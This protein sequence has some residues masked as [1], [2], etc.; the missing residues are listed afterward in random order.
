MVASLLCD[1]FI[2]CLVP[3]S[4]SN[5]NAPDCLQTS[6]EI[7]REEVEVPEFDKITVFE[8]IALVLKQGD[9]QKVE[10]ATG[11][12]LWEEL[13]VAVEGDRLILRNENGCNFFREYGLTTVYVTSPNISEIRSSTGLA[14]TSDGV[15]SYPSLT[16]LSESFLVPEAETTDG[17][18]YLDLNTGDLSIVVNGIAYFKLRGNTQNLNVNI[19]AGDSRVE[20]Q[21]L[22]SQNVSINHRGS[23]DILVNPQESISGVIRG[24]GDVISYNR[25]NT[26][27]VSVIFNGKLVFRD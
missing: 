11:E 3:T 12:N 10:V 7:I 27:D 14:I 6:G 15:L 16:L 25:P 26:V 18:F 22:V 21:A 20:A 2:I 13:S 24:Y 1:I 8:K 4:C 23:N 17:E 9:S 19:A 5:E